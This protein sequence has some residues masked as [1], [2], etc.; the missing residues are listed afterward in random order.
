M[1][2]GT[3]FNKP[4]L[5]IELIEISPHPLISPPPRFSP[6]VKIYPMQIIEDLRGL[7][8]G[9]TVHNVQVQV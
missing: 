9:F 4:P 7:N 1:S 6:N 3:N 5:K 8:R 2:G